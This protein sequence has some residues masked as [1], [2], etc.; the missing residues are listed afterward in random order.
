MK[1]IWNNNDGIFTATLENGSILTVMPRGDRFSA[2]VNDALVATRT[3][4]QRA[5]NSARWYGMNVESIKTVTPRAERA[6][7]AAEPK[8]EIE[9]GSL[10]VSLVSAAHNE[11][12]RRTVGKFEMVQLS[13]TKTELFTYA[14]VLKLKA[15]EL[16]NADHARPTDAKKALR[17]AADKILAAIA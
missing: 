6:N 4:V 8:F 15:N 11:T 9:I 3:T 16:T 10:A 2:I 17:N 7:K 13:G 5:Q 12:G 1:T 14:E